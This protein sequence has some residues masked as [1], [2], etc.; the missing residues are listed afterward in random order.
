MILAQQS[1][2]I[3]AILNALKPQG[4]FLAVLLG[5]LVYIAILCDFIMLLIPKK[6]STL[7]SILVVVGILAALLTELS[8]NVGGALV[9]SAGLGGSSIHDLLTPKTLPNFFV[10]IVMTICQIISAGT[11]TKNNA[12]NWGIFASIASILVV[13]I[14][15]AR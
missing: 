2:N 15:F 3:N 12:R 6:T 11:A 1:F 7:F 13:L 9:A 8:I 14:Q 4:D 10:Q 5:I